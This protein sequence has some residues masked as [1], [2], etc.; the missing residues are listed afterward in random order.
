MDGRT[1]TRIKGAT[2]I[3]YYTWVYCIQQI[4]AQKPLQ[5]N[6]NYPGISLHKKVDQSVCTCQEKVTKKLDS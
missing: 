1:N 6:E 2:V 4:I 5:E 3:S